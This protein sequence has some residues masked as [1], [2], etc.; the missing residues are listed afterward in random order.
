MPAGVS[1]TTMVHG[2][3][4]AMPASRFMAAISAPPAAPDGVPGTAAAVPARVSPTGT[5]AAG[6]S[7][8]HSDDPMCVS[9]TAAAV[10]HSP[11]AELSMELPGEPDPTR[12]NVHDG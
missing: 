4:A 9:P 2:T 11:A 8:V 12:T 10:L 3:A 1:P 6:A 7:P 5:A